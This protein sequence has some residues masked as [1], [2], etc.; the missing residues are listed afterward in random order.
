MPANEILPDPAP[1]PSTYPKGFVPEKYQD[2]RL[3]RE[4]MVAI[5]NSG[6]SVILNGRIINRL[7][8]LPTAVDLAGDHDELKQA[9]LSLEQQEEQIKIE[10]KKLEKRQEA[11][12]AETENEE[13]TFGDEKIPLSDFKGK[14]VDE[15]LEAEHAGIGR[16]KAERIVKLLE[17]QEESE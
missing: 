11:I 5:I 16:R 8:D 14:S 2:G 17:Q 6:G 13:E 9:E 15:I 12:N 7:A 3:T 1:V 4:S 10:R